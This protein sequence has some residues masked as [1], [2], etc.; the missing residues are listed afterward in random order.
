MKTDQTN[1][2]TGQ[3]RRTFL[4]AS[5]AALAGLLASCS[6]Q[7]EP[8]KS[9]SAMSNQTESSSSSLLA[10][11]Q[12]H[13]NFGRIYNPEHTKRLLLR[14]HRN[15]APFDKVMKASALSETVSQGIG[16]PFWWD[17]D[18]RTLVNPY[19]LAF[20]NSIK[21]ADYQ[22]AATVLNFRASQKELGDVWN[23]L[24]NNAQLNINPGSVSPEGHS[25]QWIIMTGINIAGNLFSSKDP[26]LAPLT[27]NNKPT[28]TLRA[29][30]SVTF[31]KGICTMGISL[32]A[33]KKKSFWDKL[34]SA[35]KAFVGSPVF[36]ILPIPKLY[37][38]AIES[39]TAALNELQSQSRLITVLGG[40][41]Y[42]Y[43]LYAGSNPGAD[44]TFRPGHW[45]IIDSTFASTHMDA[46]SNLSGVYLDIPG[47]LYQLKDSN[48]Q[49]VDT[50]YTVA[51]IELT[52][53]PTA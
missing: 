46:R 28:D 19:N 29:A 23:K 22:L 6:S 32:N 42:G 10:T 44:L 25:L 2:S 30:E 48:N 18:A 35:V 39:V 21:P 20:D 24:T 52:P 15:R 47:L 49:V 4:G 17:K 12:N 45:V 1:T 33:Q 7:Q 8:K 51:E 27:Q 13:F 34:L 37:E 43:K 31:R 50:T 5:A 3:S 53:V 26:Q 41:S 40:D 36:G 9:G 11:S 16:L 14:S 38:T